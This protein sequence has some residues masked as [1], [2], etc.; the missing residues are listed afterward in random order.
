MTGREVLL[1]ICIGLVIIADRTEA[2]SDSSSPMGQLKVTEPSGSRAD[3]NRPQ[4][5]THSL[6]TPQSTARSAKVLSIIPHGESG[7]ARRARIT[8]T[9]HLALNPSE[10]IGMLPVG[11]TFARKAPRSVFETFL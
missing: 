11:F 1:L 6:P 4:W 8:S 10:D 5:R 9:V 7:H 2:P 3:G